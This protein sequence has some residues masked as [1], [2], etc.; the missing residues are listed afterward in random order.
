ML[1]S[2]PAGLGESR[3][4]TDFTFV[5]YSQTTYSEV[6]RFLVVGSKGTFSQCV[7]VQQFHAFAS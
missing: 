4:K 7:Q 2:E 3:G 5:D 1:W 6:R